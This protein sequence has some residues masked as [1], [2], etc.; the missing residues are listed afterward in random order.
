MRRSGSRGGVG[1]G[2][3]D[4]LSAKGALLKLVFFPFDNTFITVVVV[5]IEKNMWS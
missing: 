5:C 2:R 3:G 4:L 1:G